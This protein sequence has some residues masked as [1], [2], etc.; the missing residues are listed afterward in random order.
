MTANHLLMQFVADVLDI[1]VEGP[2]VSESVSLG[3]AYAPGSRSVLV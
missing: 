2:L 3:A 1:P